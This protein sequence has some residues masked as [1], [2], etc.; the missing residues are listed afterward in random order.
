MW[1]VSSTLCEGDTVLV[2]IDDKRKFVIKL[3]RGRVLGTDKGYIS[4]DALIGLPYGSVVR[5]SAG[6]PA[7][8]FKPLRHDYVHGWR[9]QRR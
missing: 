2:Y 5:T 1:A 4:H 3:E 6:V 8:L 9:G 7:Y